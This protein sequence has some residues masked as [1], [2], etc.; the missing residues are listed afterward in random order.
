[1]AEPPKTIVVEEMCKGVS[2]K[3]ARELGGN[4]G[5]Y[6]IEETRGRESFEREALVTRAE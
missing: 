6:D 2:E 1:M 4:P 5:E 3:A